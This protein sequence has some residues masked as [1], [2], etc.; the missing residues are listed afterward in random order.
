MEEIS[1]IIPTWNRAA[2][3]VQAVRSVLEQS[4]PVTEILVC[5]DGSSDETKKILTDLNNKKVKFIEGARAGRP[6]IPRNRGIEKAKGE[7]IAFLD[8]DDIWLPEKIEKQIALVKKMSCLAVSSNAFRVLPGKGKVSP[9]LSID[10][11]K[12]SFADLIRTNL[13]ICSSAMLH[14]SLVEK[15]KGFPESENLKAIEDYALWLRVS[16]QTDFAY[17]KEPLVDYTDDASNS[18]RVDAKENVQR[19]SVMQ[20]FFNWTKA[21][22][23]SHE[24]IQLAKKAFRTAMKNNGR[25]FLER[26]RIK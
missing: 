7:W 2:T 17:C 6:A 22:N 14:R 9:Y 18:I 13:V 16:T 11:E 5:D 25:S 10:K 4:H 21:N 24:K 15:L 3:I 8:S 20:D 12:I 26:L 19:E 23:V 1:V